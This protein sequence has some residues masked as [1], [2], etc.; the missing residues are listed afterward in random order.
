M[1]VCQAAPHV[2]CT[3][4]D[5]IHSPTPRLPSIDVDTSASVGAK[6]DIDAISMK[7]QPPD[8]EPTKEMAQ[9]CQSSSNTS[10]LVKT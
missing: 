8:K 9:K 4:I 1:P 6:D 7:S 10:S 2:R 3:A 5:H